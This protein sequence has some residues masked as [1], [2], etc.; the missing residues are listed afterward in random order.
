MADI[1]EHKRVLVVDAAVAHRTMITAVLTNYGVT[2]FEAGDAEL[3]LRVA[4]TEPIDAFVIDIQLPRTGGIELCRSIRGLDAYGNV[5]IIFVTTLEQND[6][7]QWALDAGGDDFIHKPL[8]AVVLRAR[9]R[10]LLQKNAYLRQVEQIRQSLQRYVSPRTEGIA[11]AFAETGVLPP[12]REEEVCVLFSD[13]RGFTEMSQELPPE[14]LFHVLSEYIGAQVKQVHLH[15]GY[16][17]KF[18]GDGL[19]AVFDGEDMVRKGC[20]CALDMLDISM[21][22]VAEEKIDIH[23]L[24]IGI[25]TGPVMIGNLGSPERLDYTLI[26]PNVNL[27]A[28]LCSM[29]ERLSIVVSKSVRDCLKDDAALAFTNQRAAKLRGFKEPTPVFDLVRAGAA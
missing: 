4:R 20:L 13:M 27:A 5:P 9:L 29:A 18:S 28:R 11:R 16:V 14:T 23:Q 17:D 15:G 6:A 2:V 1:L 12:P 8:Q 21:R 26:G 7:L 3:A 19:M 22:Q 25:H 24:G 10:S